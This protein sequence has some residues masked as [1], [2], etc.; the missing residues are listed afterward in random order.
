MTRFLALG[1]I[2]LCLSVPQASY[3]RTAATFVG[4]Q[5]VLIASSTTGNV[6]SLG[7]SVVSSAPIGGDL[8]A[9]GGSIITSQIISGDQVLVAPSVRS[10]ARVYGDV[11]AFGG[12]VSVESPISGD[13][14]AGGVSVDVSG[15][16]SG[17]TA[18]AGVN[19]SMEN[20]ADGPVTI[21]ANAVHLAGMFRGDV[22][23]VA[24]GSIILAPDTHIDGALT[25]DAPEAASI[26]SSVVISGG[27]TYHSAS[28]LPDV[29][30]SRILVALSVS[31]FLFI[32]VLGALIMAG[33]LA[34]LFPRL[35]ELQADQITSLRP[36]RL[37]L[38]ALL[39]FAVFVVMPIL[40]ILLAITFVGLGLAFLIMVAY[41][42]LALLSLMYAGIFLGSLTA[43]R[44]RRRERVYW[45]DGV[46]GMLIFSLITLV[47]YI[48]VPVVFFLMTLSAGTL[49]TLF[50]EFA[51]G[52]DQTSQL[53]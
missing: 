9:V 52:T 34:G 5:S 44:L 47:P 48:G 22:T 6:Y 26:P 31:V 7:A 4:G 27:T 15:R 38:R 24:S 51:F 45:H 3:A 43:R 17:T 19:V 35:A 28:V 12:R 46:L 37:L 39:G 50:F 41:S 29:G 42:A 13:L 33:L 23:I 18:L 16:T 10:S 20:G 14:V 30:T 36:S 32:R 40:A 21:Y 1:I 8:F 25:Y 2:A 53:L 11:R 49:V